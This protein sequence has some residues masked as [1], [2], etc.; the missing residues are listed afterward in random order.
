MTEERAEMESYTER[1]VSK[2]LDQ[3]IDAQFEVEEVQRRARQYDTSH[4]LPPTPPERFADVRALAD[5]ASAQVRHEQTLDQLDKD[6][7]EAEQR[8]RI[9]EGKVAALLPLGSTVA[10][11]Y[12][13][14]NPDEYGVLCEITH[15]QAFNHNSRKP[16]DIPNIRVRWFRG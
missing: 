9:V 15:D 1:N 14:A 11:G 7:R 12:G 8:L 4:P 5:Y 13:G 6:Q 2:L 3:F 16:V 10:H